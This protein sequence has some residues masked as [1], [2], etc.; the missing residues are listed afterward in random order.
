MMK[1]NILEENMRRF[2]TKNLNE[3]EDQ[4]NNGYPDGT[5]SSEITRIQNEWIKVTTEI[6]DLVNKH[7]SADFPEQLNISKQINA[8]GNRKVSLEAELI[9]AIVGNDK[10][11]RLLLTQQHHPTIFR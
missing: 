9:D 5:E 6:A 3:D 2:N 8:N 10:D 11:M 7:K 1:K 4:N